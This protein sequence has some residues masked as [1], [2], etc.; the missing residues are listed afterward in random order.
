MNGCV[1]YLPSCGR[2]WMSDPMMI[3]V[4]TSAYIWVVFVLQ[5]GIVGSRR[6]QENQAELIL[7]LSYNLQDEFHMFMFFWRVVLAQLP[8]LKLHPRHQMNPMA[9]KMMSKMSA[10]IF[11]FNV[12]FLSP[13]PKHNKP[14]CWS[15][16]HVFSAS[17]LF[18]WCHPKRSTIFLQPTLMAS[19][20]TTNPPLTYLP[21]DFNKASR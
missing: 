8:E 2:E 6:W 11:W 17:S 10:M 15:S 5:V 1:V 19:Q 21:Q 14:G 18:F 16:F 9:T 7:Q 13:H 4:N 3:I 12:M 20:P